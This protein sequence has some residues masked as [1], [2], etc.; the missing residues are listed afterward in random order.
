[1]KAKH[2]II[3]NS[4]V[5]ITDHDTPDNTL[6]FLASNPDL[7]AEMEYNRALQ[8]WK[9][10]A[11]EVENKEA[12]FLKNGCLVG[13]FT[14][15]DGIYPAPDGLEF[16]IIEECTLSI[17]DKKP[18][19][20]IENC[21]C[22]HD[23]TPL[24]K[25][26]VV[27]FKEQESQKGL[28]TINTEIINDF[29]ITKT[30][31]DGQLVKVESSPVEDFEVDGYNN[32]NYLKPDQAPVNDG[33]ISVKDRLPELGEEYNVVW[34]LKDGGEPLTTTVEWDSIRKIWFDETYPDGYKDILFWQPLPP[35]PKP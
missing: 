35:P 34:D 12:L 23:G 26:A 10:R 28:F 16:E 14:P 25:V 29:N 21:V 33:W 1:M 4:R 17:T 24:K 11:Y 3:E 15:I 27:T 2:L 5:L 6:N 8:S 22:A 18:C 7:L 9:D 13:G 31:K 19:R 20:Q 30:Y 32:T